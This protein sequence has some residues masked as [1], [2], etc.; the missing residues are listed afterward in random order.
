VWVVK[1]GTSDGYLMLID[2]QSGNTSV[3]GRGAMS[4]VWPSTQS[5][6][7]YEHNGMLV[8]R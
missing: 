6:Y 8:G 5:S 3:V 4:P 7:I 1:N 2:P